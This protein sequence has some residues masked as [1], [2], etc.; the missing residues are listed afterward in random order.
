[1][2]KKLSNKLSTQEDK[3][4]KQ[5]EEYVKKLQKVINKKY[6]DDSPNVFAFYFKEFNN[7]IAVYVNDGHSDS[8]DYVI[9]LKY[10]E[11]DEE[12]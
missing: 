8:G 4:R 9:I 10:S 2:N 12:E 5:H 7:E 11:V 3:I 6:P 1:M